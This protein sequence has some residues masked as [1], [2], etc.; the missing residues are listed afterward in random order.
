MNLNGKDPTKES[1]AL[2]TGLDNQS[3]IINS[4]PGFYSGR[5]AST[6]SRG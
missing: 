4:K 2:E 6:N 5:R 1:S 3:I